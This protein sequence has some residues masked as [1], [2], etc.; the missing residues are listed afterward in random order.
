M[1]III[2]GGRSFD[3]RQL[4]Y[5]V[6]DKV[7]KKLDKKKLVILSGHAEGAD[8]LGEEW[9]Y[10]R[11]VGT[12]RVHHPDWNKHKKAAGVIRNGEMV[13]EADGLVA[14][15]DGESKGTEDVII[16]ARKAKLKVKI[17]MY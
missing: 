5:S 17:V 12:V 15:W 2:A 9:A 4:L 1:R 3:D 13:A 16:R 10:S 7:T 14:F 6:M 11:M 8:K